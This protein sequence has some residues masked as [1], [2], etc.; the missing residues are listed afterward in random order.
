[1]IT[2]R[3]LEQAEA[4]FRAAALRAEANRERR[5]AL[6]HE[7]VAEGWSHG[8]LAS[9]MGLSRSRVSQLAPPRSD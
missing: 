3:K 9:A 6:I 8:R 7:A 2:N 1:M 4:A 5:N